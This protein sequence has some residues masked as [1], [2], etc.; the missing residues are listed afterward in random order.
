MVRDKYVLI[1]AAR[2]EEDFIELYNPAPDLAVDL[3]G[4]SLQ[5]VGLAFP[6]VTILP[7]DEHLVIVR[8]QSVFEADH[9][10]GLP[11]AAEYSGSL[12]NDGEV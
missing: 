9:G 5:G 2:N 7:A 3:S 8:D 10:T 11:V 1:T 4:W 6:D 12:G